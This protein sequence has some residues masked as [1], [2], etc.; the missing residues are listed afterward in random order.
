MPKKSRNKKAKKHS[1]NIVTKGSFSLRKR[2]RYTM[3]ELL[4]GMNDKS[5]EELRRHGDAVLSGGPVG[6]ELA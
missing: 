4:K 1:A 3:S 6:D 2:K 5:A